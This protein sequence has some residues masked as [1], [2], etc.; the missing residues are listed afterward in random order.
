MSQRFRNDFLTFLLVDCSQ[1]LCLLLLFY[2]A[3]G[4]MHIFLTCS[5]LLCF[6]RHLCLLGDFVPWGLPLIMP[7]CGHYDWAK[8]IWLT[9]RPVLF[10]YITLSLFWGSRFF[11]GYLLFKLTNQ[12]SNKKCDK[13]AKLEGIC[14]RKNKL[15][16]NTKLERDPKLLCS[17][18]LLMVLHL[19]CFK[20]DSCIAN[21]PNNE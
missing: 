14:K 9:K 19:S 10:S 15:I 17:T 6:D 16:K 11:S 2:Q 18:L 8:I 5:N 21:N 13:K 7:W 12:F 20:K 1:W 3:L 4:M